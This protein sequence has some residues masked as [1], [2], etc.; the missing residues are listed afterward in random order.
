M[1]LMPVSID[2]ANNIRNK[3]DTA[4]AQA[5]WRAVQQPGKAVAVKTEQ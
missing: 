2:I 5:I 3:N 4:D 1:K